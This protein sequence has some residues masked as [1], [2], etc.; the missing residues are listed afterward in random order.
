MIAMMMMITTMITTTTTMTMLIGHNLT[1]IA[2]EQ[3][4]NYGPF[5]PSL[6]GSQSQKMKNVLRIRHT[7]FKRFQLKQNKKDN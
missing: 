5:E 3:I 6:L 2:F 1:N 4:K 7:E